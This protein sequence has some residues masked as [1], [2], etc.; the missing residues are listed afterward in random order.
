MKFLN[1]MIVL[2]LIGLVLVGCSAS[3]NKNETVSKNDVLSGSISTNGSTSM[4]HVMG[5]LSF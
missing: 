1:K 4:E 5:L 2:L 3:S